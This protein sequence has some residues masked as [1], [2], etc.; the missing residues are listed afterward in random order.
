MV[1]KAAALILCLFVAKTFAQVTGEVFMVDKDRDLFYVHYTPELGTSDS[2]D[3][4]KVSS[5]LNFPVIRKRLSI[6]N[7]IGVDYHSFSFENSNRP[8]ILSTNEEYFHINYSIL[9]N[10]KISQNWS[11]NA[12][13]MPY[14]NGSFHNKLT[15]KDI[16]FNGMLFAEK[17][18]LSRS[19]KNTYIL[20]FGIGYLTMSGEKRVNPVVNFRG[21][22]GNQLT[23]ALGLPNTY[24]KYDFNKKHSIKIL[25][26]LN[27][28]T[29]QLDNRRNENEYA[30]LSQSV[31]TT[32]SAGLEYN[33]WI[34][35]SIGLLCRGTHSIF[36]KYEFQDHDKKVLYD[37]KPPL[38]AY[39]SV[40]LKVNP[41][42][43]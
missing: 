42:R 14:I 30:N 33:F 5:K 8:P 22:I 13:V 36:E 39:I 6:F 21:T 18:F 23:F 34:T 24:V 3:Y 17:R 26:D 31:F 32:V 16:H 40:G 1:K 38:R 7:T 4:Q 11:L 37:V 35:K 19:T 20:S 29:L 15:S 41:F 27:D 43:R 12:L 28:F 9:A 25:G 2:F 10:Y